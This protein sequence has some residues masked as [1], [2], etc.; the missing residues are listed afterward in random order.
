M[1]ETTVIITGTSRG[2]GFETAKYFAGLDNCHIYALSRDKSGLKRLAEECRECCK[3]SKLIPVVFDFKNFLQDPAGFSLPEK[4][5]HINI[6]I[7]NAGFLINRPFNAINPDEAMQMLQINF[8]GPALLIRE[9]SSSM[10]RAGD[11]HIVNIGSMGGYQGSS[12]Y[13][14]LSYYSASKAALANLT[15]SLSVEY[16]DMHI[17]INCL[18]LGSVQTEM[19]SKAF[20]GYEAPVKPKDMASFIG[21]FALNGHKFMNGKVI[22]VALANP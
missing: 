20:P 3:T 10:G 21:H 22:P 2:I 14:G 4:P 12:R 5:D 18:A 13:P 8:L 1:P 19:L 16:K 9:L 15:E 11:T 7:N 17:I 6:L